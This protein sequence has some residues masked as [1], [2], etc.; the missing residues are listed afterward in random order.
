MNGDFNTL[1]V[2][3]KLDPVLGDEMSEVEEDQKE[4]SY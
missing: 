1:V 2:K 3:G 4:E